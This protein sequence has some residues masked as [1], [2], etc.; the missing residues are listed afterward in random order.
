MD[1]FA[2]KGIRKLFIAVLILL[3]LFIIIGQVMVVL[4]TN[5]FT[6]GIIKHDY[7]VA[8]YLS[9]E[10][11]ALN[12]EGYALARAFTAEKSEG[13]IE[14]GRAL[15]LPEAYDGNTRSLWLPEAV[16]F[17]RRYSVLVL[18]LSVPFSLLVLA[19]LYIY[20]RNLI[21]NMNKANDDLSNFLG[22]NYEVRL[23][24]VDEGGISG[25]FSTINDMAASLTAHISREKQNKEFLRD[26]ISDIS[27]QLKTPLAALQMYHEI[28]QSKDISKNDMDIFIDKSRNELNRMENLIKNLL[29]MAELDANSVELSREDCNLR[30]LLEQTIQSFLTRAESEKK[31][32]NMICDDRLVINC[33]AEWLLEAVSNIVKNALDHTNTGDTVGI[34]CDDTPV[35]TKVTIRDSGSGIHPEDLHH[36]FKRFYRSRFSKDRQGVGIG[37]TLSK[38]IVEKHGGTI[39]IESE[40]GKGTAFH[41]IFPKLTNV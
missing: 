16:L 4:L 25:L 30:E 6:N 32:L 40:P 7:G 5:D 21:K 17:S 10:P 9:R 8:G 36:I 27:H 22:G 15:L 38:S 19:I 13:D 1:I 31:T 2:V 18:G 26:T 35:I 37:L 3:L 41:L 33:D 34:I 12:T 39:S 11:A 20:S 23:D 28:I 29:K 24:D 14:A